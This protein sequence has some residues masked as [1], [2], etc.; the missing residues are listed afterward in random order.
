MENI[1]YLLSAHNSCIEG[2]CLSRKNNNAFITKDSVGFST[3]RVIDSAEISGAETEQWASRIVEFLDQH[4]WRDHSIVFLLP[5]EYVTFRKLTFP[6]QERKKVEQALPFE[7]EEE[8]MGDL[9]ETAYSVQVNQMTEQNS[10]ALVLLI[11]HERLQQLQ[12]ICLKRDLLIRNV[13][14]AAHALYRTLINNNSPTPKTQDMYQIY[15]GGD[16]SF[17]NT[18]REGGLDEIKIFPNRI[19]EILQQHI[20]TAGNS[21]TA[22]L[23]NFAKHSEGVDRTAGNSAQDESFV[24]LKE[25][26]SL[27]CVKLT[28]HLRIKN[29]NSKSEIEVH[30]I[31]GPM[32]K[33]D[34]VKFKIRS[35]PLPEAEAFSERS[36]DNTTIIHAHSETS[37][38]N[39]IT[40]NQ[41]ADGKSPDTLEE[42]MVEAKQRENSDKNMQND[43]DE[44]ESTLEMQDE[45]QTA[46]VPESVNPKASLLSLLDR[47]HWGIL[48][49]LRKETEL[50][51]ESHRLSLHHESTPWR[52]F[53]RRNR[54][55]LAFAASLMII[56]SVSLVWQT[57]TELN[58][59]QQEIERAESLIQ[60]ELRFALPQTSST[61]VNTMLLELE[62]KIKRR[63]V[64]IEIS[65]NFE[66]RDYHNLRF[67]KYISAILSE[68]APFQVGSLEYIPEHF[69]FSGTIDSYDR[70]QILKNNLKEIEEFKSKRIVESNRKSPEGIIYRI[71]IDLK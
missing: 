7:L 28:L 37:D 15:L 2:I 6:F 70:L 44:I 32:I 31:L 26:L 50:F 1:F 67:L 35:F 62:E 20:S 4:Q 41:Q 68:D 14:C 17:V 53:L 12:Q 3:D 42:L 63:K 10:E 43:V 34:G 66:K 19:P 71:S 21:L 11:G 65:K 27:L 5:A 40:T 24:Q 56:I 8:L 45:Q 22:F 55:A 64:Y 25:E 57:R 47:K 61:D 59:L 23:Q 36:L 49:E 29:Y 46:R 13:D 33:W 60:T 48:G 58:L 9:T 51:L 16:E 52:R 39:E 54:L 38:K 18:V 69:T 30:G